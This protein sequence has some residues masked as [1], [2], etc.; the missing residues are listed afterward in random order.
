MLLKSSSAHAA[1]LLLVSGDSL[2]LKRLAAD[3][4]QR[5]PRDADVSPMLDERQLSLAT[6]A[7]SFLYC[8]C[9]S[10]L[11]AAPCRS[12]MTPN[13]SFLTDQP[14]APPRILQANVSAAAVPRCL[15]K[16]RETA[17]AVAAD[18]A[19]ACVASSA[20]TPHE[21]QLLASL[22]QR[23]AALQAELEPLFP[24]GGYHHGAALLCSCLPA[25][26]PPARQLAEA[27]LEW[28]RRPEAAEERQLELARAAAAR[29]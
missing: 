28:W 8:C 26:L 25:L 5:S 15:W 18:A 21:E 10:H 12:A 3:D 4:L 17:A 24:G 14:Y 20:P 2:W 22:R 1:V 27:L 9:C 29:R 23:Q 13:S 7:S 16:L 6:V 11:Y 19:A